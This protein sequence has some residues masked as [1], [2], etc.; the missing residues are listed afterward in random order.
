MNKLF[1]HIL[2]VSLIV[3]GFSVGASGIAHIANA[4]GITVQQART[5]ESLG[6]KWVVLGSTP[7]VEVFVNLP[8]HNAPAN[9]YNKANVPFS[10]KVKWAVCDNR[11]FTARVIT[12]YDVNG[13]LHSNIN[14]DANTKWKQVSNNT[15]TE[16]KCGAKYCFTQRNYSSNGINMS[17]VKGNHTTLQ[18]ISKWNAFAVPDS[19]I[20]SAGDIHASVVNIHLHWAPQPTPTPTIKPTPKPTPK[21]TIKPTPKPTV[22]PTPTPTPK[23]TM[24]PTPTPVITATC[25]DGNGNVIIV[26]DS[27]TINCNVNKNTN[28]NTISLNID[29]SSNNSSDN[30]SS[31]NNEVHVEQK[32]ET[33][34]VKAPTAKKPRIAA[35]V[36]HTVP[37]YVA[38]SVVHVPVTA[39]TGPTGLA[40]LLFSTLTGGSG[41]AYVI[42]KAII[43]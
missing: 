21:P 31:N 39:K 10:Y 7:V 36:T 5:G 38:P 28:A 1:T 32:V 11:P 26:T 2:G 16:T 34:T 25:L 9:T 6:H 20:P 37:A 30:S 12:R 3:A 33:K 22:K 24:T 19:S 41:L 4:N 17:D 13:G 42:R 40:T 35:A 15:F 18:V 14:G 29:N 27:S 8:A 23:P 43:G